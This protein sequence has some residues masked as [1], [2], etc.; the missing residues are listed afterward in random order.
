LKKLSLEQAKLVQENIPLANKIARYHSAW[1]QSGKLSLEDRKSEAYL[2]L[3]EAAISWNPSIAAFKTYA[4]T[5]IKNFII[6]A[7]RQ[8]NSPYGMHARVHMIL[9]DMNRAVSKGVPNN[10]IAVA[11]AL[12][13][14]INKVKELWAYH[15]SGNGML[16]IPEHLDIPNE[17]EDLENDV[18][19]KVYNEDLS[20]KIGS[21]VNS[22]PDLLRD[23]VR[24]RFGFHDGKPMLSKEIMIVMN[25][26]EREYYNLEAEAMEILKQLIDKESIE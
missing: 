18:V 15:L 2:G 13:I 24:Y 11:E 4:T 14:N 12:N 21:V 6:A 10:P 20:N 7:S 8:N 25:I 9:R 23:I 19:N 17:K 22:L 1:E 5:V 16:G 3:V 26:K